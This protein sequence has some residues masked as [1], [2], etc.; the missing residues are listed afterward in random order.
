M[1]NFTFDYDCFS[2]LYKD[3]NGFRPRGHEFYAP[4]TTDERRQ[5]IWDLYCRQLDVEIDRQRAEEAEAVV[6]FEA[7]IAEL[8]SIG[9]GDR[10]TALRWIRERD[11]E[12]LEWQFGLPFGY[13]SGTRPGFIK[14]VA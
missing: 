7:K 1:T 6:R 10:E 12:H 5:E 9:A 11:D 8:I 13:L 3:V 14:E 2:D 4:E